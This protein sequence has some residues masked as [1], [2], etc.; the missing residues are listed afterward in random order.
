[1]QLWKQHRNLAALAAVTFLGGAL[2]KDVRWQANWSEDWGKAADAIDSRLRRTSGCVTFEPAGD[3][4]HYYFFRPELKAK[5]CGPAPDQ[6][7]VLLA[8]SPYARSGYRIP[9]QTKQNVGNTLLEVV[10]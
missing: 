3:A 6:G 1:M 5:T 4:K 7:P 8:I 2:V 9:A 10:R